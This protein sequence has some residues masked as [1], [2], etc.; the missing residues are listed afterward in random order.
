MEKYEKGMYAQLTE[1]IEENDRLVS[2][3]K[4]LREENRALKK[5]VSRL[6]TRLSVMEET[7]EER[8]QK[9][10]TAAVTTA[11]EPLHAEIERKE[12]EIKRLK[13]VIDK[14]SSNS[15]KPP[16]SD[17][18]KKIP[19][20]R[21]PSVKK[22]GGQHGH[23]GITLTIPKNLFEL[24]ESGKA[25]HEVIDLTN[26]S[27]EYVTKWEIDIKTKTIYREYRC[28]LGERSSICYGNNVKAYSVLLLNEGFMSLERVSE[29][30]EEIT[31]GQVTASVA[32]LE[33][34][35][36]EASASVDVEALKSDLL[37][38]DVMNVDETSLR[39]TER[40][41]NDEVETAVKTTFDVTVR[42]HSNATTT[43][44]TINPRKDDE[45]VVNDGIIP[46]FHGILS[47]DHDRKYYKYG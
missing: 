16:S 27:L 45:G 12:V 34:F 30:L 42:T 29:F 35:N 43:L 23:K 47:H 3:V 20:N 21:E 39:S 36:I 18:F 15:G 25:E 1:T 5:E 4:N 9:A 17:G 22:R 28:P 32:T 10:V 38:G 37:N 40:I 14:D 11:V 7:L 13:S 19:N 31:Y 44:Y 26:G 6:E 33:K 41:E 24:V 2:E 46:A 8:I